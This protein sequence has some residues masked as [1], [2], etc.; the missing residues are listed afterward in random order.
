MMDKSKYIIEN[1]PYDEINADIVSGAES[2]I[3]YISILPEVLKRY[4]KVSPFY[5]NFYGIDLDCEKHHANEWMNLDEC[6]KTST[7]IV[8]YVDR[9]GYDLFKKFRKEMH[10]EADSL[11]KYSLNLIPRL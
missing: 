9:D 1:E 6:E 11:H 4:N 5:W 3:L 2:S 7:E 10:K 8:N